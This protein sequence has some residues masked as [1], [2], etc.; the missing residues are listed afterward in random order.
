MVT[1][2]ANNP[3]LVNRRHKS[4]IGSLISYSKQSDEHNKWKNEIIDYLDTEDGQR[5]LNS[6]ALCGVTKAELKE[7]IVSVYIGYHRLIPKSNELVGDE[8]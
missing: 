6:H 3:V 7:A 1:I 8:I 5:I 4:S 2:R